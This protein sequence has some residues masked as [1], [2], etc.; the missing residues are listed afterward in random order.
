MILTIKSCLNINSSNMH[1]YL[2]VCKH[3]WFVCALNDENKITPFWQLFGGSTI[4]TTCTKSITKQ[5]TKTFFVTTCYIF[6]LNYDI[7]VLD[8]IVC[9]PLYVHISH[10]LHHLHIYWIFFTQISEMTKYEIHLDIFAYFSW[11]LTTKYLKFRNTNAV[12]MGYI[13]LYHKSQ[14]H[15]NAIKEGNIQREVVA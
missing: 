11:Y 15:G 1:Q 5:K 4:N 10:R 7:F 13:T 2:F 6:P 14:E 12:A 9:H 8:I 3:C